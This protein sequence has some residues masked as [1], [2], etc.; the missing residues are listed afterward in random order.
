M[1]NE[2]I[3]LFDPADSVTGYCGG[4]ITGKRFVRITGNA[5]D[6]LATIGLGI[7]GGAK[8]V[9]VSHR[10]AASTAKVGIQKVG[11]VPVT[12]GEA[13][14]AG[15]PITSGANGVAMIADSPG[16]VILG[17]AWADAADAADVYVD[18][19][20]TGAGGGLLVTGI[21]VADIATADAA[22]LATAIALANA[23]KAKVNAL[24]A[25][26]RTAKVIAP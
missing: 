14:T 17:R 24:L 25:V 10:D 26:L 8:T 4:A 13:I 3:P 9:G 15:D 16:D 23:T 2:L 6:G 12:A 7:A 1:A 19:G 5:V 20:S 18:L 11:I 22:D 21:A